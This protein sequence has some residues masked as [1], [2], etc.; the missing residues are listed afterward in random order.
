MHRALAA[1]SH[2]SVVYVYAFVGLLADAKL[3]TPSWHHLGSAAGVAAV[4]ALHK[5]AK[6]YG[7]QDI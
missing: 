1:L 4:A 3:D 7:A 5:L 6:N 2:A